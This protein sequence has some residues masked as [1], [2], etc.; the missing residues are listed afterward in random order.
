MAVSN[1]AA[2]GRGQAEAPAE[3]PAP[4]V[5]T[6]PSTRCSSW[7]AARVS[8]SRQRHVPSGLIFGG[9]RLIR[10]SSAGTCRL[11]ARRGQ[12]VRIRLTIEAAPGEQGIPG[13]A[14][15]VARSSDRRPGRDW[16]AVRLT[17]WRGTE[18]AGSFKRRPP[19][20][21]R[22]SQPHISDP[23]ASH[24]SSLPAGCGCPATSTGQ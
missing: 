15:T 9:A 10:L 17:D 7:R 23:V 22:V 20:T 21:A 8:A 24:G 19:S 2:D 18:H 6:G 11:E 1:R 13:C 5:L 4:D 3:L 14:A 16:P 12:G